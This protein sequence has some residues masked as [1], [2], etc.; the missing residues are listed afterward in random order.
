MKRQKKSTPGDDGIGYDVYKNLPDSKKILLLE[1]FNL[2][3]EINDFPAQCKHSVLIPIAKPGKDPHQL[4]S[5]RPIALTSSFMKIME[6]M[7]NKRLKFFAEKHNVLGNIQH[8]F[9]QGRGT[10]DN[11][12]YL[13][14][15]IL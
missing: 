9:R 7:V 13:E 1:L 14:N 8:G 6:S 12:V 10:I 15:D 5:Y 4:S 11:V 2:I 3:W